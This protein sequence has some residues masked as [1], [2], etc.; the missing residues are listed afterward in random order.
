[1]KRI[2]IL[3]LFSL[4]LPTMTFASTA[5]EIKYLPD[6]RPA[7]VRDPALG[8]VRTSV[9]DNPAPSV[10]PPDSLTATR[11]SIRKLPK[12]IEIDLSEQ[13]LSYYYGT[14][15]VDG[16][17]I[18]SGLPKTPTPVGTFKVLEKIPVKAYRGPGY[19]LPNTKWN[20]KFLASGYYVH[21]AYWHNKFG[22]PMSHGCVN[23]SYADMEQLYEFADV[24]IPI[25]IRR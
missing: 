2:F 16:F 9:L 19:Y 6:G 1:M 3:I 8:P 18:S 4:L 10:A 23:V 21:G 25:I 11:D 15:R 17:K 20:L 5:G 14:N 22:R 13:S 7:P 12:R 24:G